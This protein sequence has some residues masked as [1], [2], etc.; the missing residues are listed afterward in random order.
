M[1]SSRWIQ[2]KR[3]GCPS[4]PSHPEVIFTCS[5][6]SEP[7]SYFC[8]YY[9]RAANPPPLVFPW[10]L[11]TGNREEGRVTWECV[12]GGGVGGRGVVGMQE[13][14]AP[15][16]LCCVYSQ[17]YCLL[18]LQPASVGCLGVSRLLWQGGRDELCPSSQP[19]KFKHSLLIC[20][21]L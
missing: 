7:K 14:N 18:Q 21:R 17:S 11:H 9:P 16:F 15:G 4:T 13:R 3:K 20:Y 10:P 5:S 1:F 2:P 8:C 19:T 12:C 6:P